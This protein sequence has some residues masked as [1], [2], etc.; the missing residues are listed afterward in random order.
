MKRVT[1][2]GGK[3]VRLKDLAGRR[4]KRDVWIEEIHI[5]LREEFDRLRKLSVK[6][7]LIAM[8]NLALDIIETS[9]SYAYSIKMLHPR[10]EKH[11]LMKMYLSWFQS[12]T[13]SFRIVSGT[14]RGRYRKSPKKSI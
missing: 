12:F 10:M 1:E 9:D 14:H 6:F 4:R 2:H 7:N 13:E 5:Y 11:L 3:I 8:R